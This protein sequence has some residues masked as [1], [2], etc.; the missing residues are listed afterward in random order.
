MKKKFN[1][2]NCILGLSICGGLGASLLAGHLFG[3][4]FPILIFAY[5]VAQL[6][7]EV[8][9]DNKDVKKNK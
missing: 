8:G 9:T 4:F 5:I 2:F 3:Y 6:F 1:M 7:Q